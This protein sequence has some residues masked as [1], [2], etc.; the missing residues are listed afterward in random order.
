LGRIKTDGE[1]HQNRNSENSETVKLGENAVV[2]P[3]NTTLQRNG[4][5]GENHQ[6]R[7][8]ENDYSLIFPIFEQDFTN[9]SV[10]VSSENRETSLQDIQKGAG[11]GV[12]DGFRT[13]AYCKKRLGTVESNRKRG[14]VSDKTYNESIEY[15][16]NEIAKAQAREG[17]K[18]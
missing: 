2:N 9:P 7:N 11:Q 10:V 18:K 17:L 1:I 12:S 5:N 4:E 8:S 3:I 14:Q 13:V 16:K 15:W 6:T